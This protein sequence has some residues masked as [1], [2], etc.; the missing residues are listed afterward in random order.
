MKT[1]CAGIFLVAL[2]ATQAAAFSQTEFHLQYGKLKN[3][4]SAAAHPTFV[5]TV[6]QAAAWKWGESFF[7]ID[8][9]NDD[10]RDG[11]NDRDFYGEWYPTL[12]FGKLA[13]RELR[14]GPIRDFALIAGVNLGGD[15]NVVKY[16]PGLRASWDLPGFLFLNTDLTA[17]ID[18]NTGGVGGGAPQEDNSFMVDVSWALPFSVGTQSLAI[19]G[20]AE[21]LGRRTDKSGRTVKGSILAQPQF[22]WDLGKALGAPHQLMVGIEYQYWLNKLG[23]DEDESTAQLLVVWRL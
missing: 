16:L 23:T 5:F 3:P 22:T 7:F 21:Y 2:L 1:A 9:L 14:V 19:V 4:F 6:Q 8:Y 15:A 20:H 13:N 10:T 18:A 12:S 17:Y 11:F